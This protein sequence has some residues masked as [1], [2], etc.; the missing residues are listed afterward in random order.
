MS[1][2]DG[3]ERGPVGLLEAISDADSG[4]DRPWTH[5]LPP[6]GDALH[7]NVAQLSG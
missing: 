2:A 5:H 6:R 7:S 1:A 4:A 3:E